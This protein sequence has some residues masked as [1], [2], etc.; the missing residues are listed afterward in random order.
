MENIEI[1]DHRAVRE[2]NV[3]C[4]TVA[5]AYDPKRQLLCWEVRY[6]NNADTKNMPD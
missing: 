6:R 1:R 3:R 4:V 2:S 5:S